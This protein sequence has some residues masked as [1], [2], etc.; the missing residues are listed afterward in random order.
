MRWLS[1]LKMMYDIKPYNLICIYMYI[2][3]LL[4]FVLL[5]FRHIMYLLCYR[6][7]DCTV[8]PW[9][10]VTNQLM[11]LKR[12]YCKEYSE[13]RRRRIEMKSNR[14]LTTLLNDANIVATF[15]IQGIRLAGSRAKDRHTWTVMKWKPNKSRPKARYRQR[16]EDREL[17]ILR[18]RQGEELALELLK[19]INLYDINILSVDIR[20]LNPNNITIVKAIINFILK[21]SLHI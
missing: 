11:F 20:V 6:L 14:G 9:S 12:K 4:Y 13:K 3:L 7:I 19:C 16:L 17:K 5:L 15:K 2:C 8:Y 10:I 1:E 18:Y 21:S